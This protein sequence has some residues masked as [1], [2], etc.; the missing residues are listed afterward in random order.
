MVQYLE[1]QTTTVGVTT[2]IVFDLLLPSDSLFRDS[3]VVGTAITVSGIQTGYYFVVS[4][5]NIGNGVTSL[6]SAGAVV[7]SG[8]SFLDNIYEVASVS[9]AQT[10]AVAIGQTYVAKVTVSVQKL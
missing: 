2:G 6:N 9:I 3:D 4:N 5:S 1:Y 7:G 10:N 8:S